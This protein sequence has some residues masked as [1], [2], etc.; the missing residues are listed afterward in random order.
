M[1]ILGVATSVSVVH[2]VL[3]Q[4]VTSLLSIEQFHTQHSALTLAQ[5]MDR[6]RCQESVHYFHCGYVMQVL[7]THQFP[8]NLGPKALRFLL[9]QFYYCN[10]SLADFSHGLKVGVCVCTV[11]IVP[12]SPSHCPVCDD[13]ALLLE[14][15]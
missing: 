12:P 7:L 8:F 13:G 2:R 1:L 15:T 10:F 14:P 5:I 6:V 4:R 11:G 9:H 3:P